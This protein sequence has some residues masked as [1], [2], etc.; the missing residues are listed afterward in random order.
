M[1]KNNILLGV[2]ILLV[3]FAVFSGKTMPNNTI[4]IDIPRPISDVSE[5]IKNISTIIS[6]KDDKI[7]LCV[8]NKVFA[9]RVI[10]YD[11]DQQ[12]LND[13]YVLAAKNMFGDSLRDKYNGLDEIIRD[14]IRS[15]TGD[16]NHEL[17]NDEKSDIQTNF[18]AIS[19]YLKE[20]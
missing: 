8:F 9:D 17:T 2:G 14:A 3:V 11:T 4:D 10:N 20:R 6:D 18:Y 1:K 19:W 12:K 7:E 15:I 16:D 13:V 5:S